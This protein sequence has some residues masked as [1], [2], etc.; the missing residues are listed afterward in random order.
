MRVQL[1]PSFV[2]KAKALPGVERTVYW[3]AQ[4]P[5]F[6]LVVTAGGHRGFV[7]QYRAARRS[8]RLTMKRVLTLADARKEAHAVLGAVA[9][10]G[11]P[12]AERRKTD[13]TA[14]N[15]LY[16]IAEEYLGREAK[17]LRSIEQRRA[18]LE[19]LV[20]PKFGARQIDS[21]RRSEIVRLLDKIED[22]SGPVMA[23]QTLAVL[24]RLLTWHAGRSDDFRSPV[25]RGMTRTSPKE[26]ARQRK[27]TDDEL[28]AIW[29]AADSSR[30]PFGKM[31]QYILL[32]ATRRNEAA[33]MRREE[34]S[35]A[36]W[37]IP[38][39]RHKSKR[40]F[41]LPLSSSAIAVLNRVPVIDRRGDY[42]FTTDG[43]RPLSGFSKFKRE[44]DK[45]CGV[46][47]WTLHDLRRTARSLMSRAG[48]DPDHAERALAHALPGI[49]GT[50]DVHEY[51]EEKKRAFG[52]LAAQIER[53]LNPLQ[54]VVSLH[55][56]RA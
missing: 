23:D 16:S 12:L 38:S 22:E 36:D 30:S 34:V 24:R 42:V 47:G 3:D 28:R 11:D 5:G 33:R 10:G 21:I 45:T 37:L 31:V 48:I 35:D 41:L 49:R 18:I 14:A 13:A 9:K 15:T 19:R 29:R 17:R 27:L 32:T 8:R 25:V 7:V 50:Y 55:E 1:T 2:A 54:N 39:S 26:R 46:I 51:Y 4:M 6:G 20:Y 53:I 56:S 44:F 43:V 52:A 40:D